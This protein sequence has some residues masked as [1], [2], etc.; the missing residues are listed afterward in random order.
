MVMPNIGAF[1]A[2][3][4]VTALFLA[5]GWIPNEYLA[6]LI[7]PTLTYLL[8]IL[9]GYTGGKIVHGVRGGVI[10]AVATVGCIIGSE[11]TMLA[12]AMVMG[13][14][15]AWVLKKFDTAV[16]PHV[17]P[18]FE[19]LVDNFSLGIIG[20]FLMVIS[21]V[22]VGP[23][24]TA[25]M[26]VLS[27][28]AQAITDAG[29]LPLLA[30]FVR[31]GQLLFLNNAINHG[32]LVPL[33]TQ[34]VADFGRSILFFVEADNSVL[35]GV[36]LAY[37]FFGTG[38]AKQSAP[39]ALIICMFGGI[40]EIQFP[41]VLMKPKLVVAP[42][43]GSMCSLAFLQLFGGGA[44]AAPSPGSIFAYLLVSPRDAIVVNMI[45]YVI[46]FGVSFLISAL[47]LKTDKSGDDDSEAVLATALDTMSGGTIGAEAAA[48]AV[49]DA[50]SGSWANVKKIVVACDAG[51]G[52]SAM[53]E[54]VL[55]N[56]LN[57]E[58]ITATV[59]HSSLNNIPDDADLVI[60]LEGLLGR[61]QASVNRRGVIFVGVPNF[62][63][64][65]DFD[66]IA[67]NLKEGRDTRLPAPTT[68]TEQENPVRIDTDI[69][70]TNNVRLNQ[71]FATKEDAIR[72]AGQ[73]L[74]DGGYVKPEYID[75]M[76]ERERDI[77]VYIGN[78]VAIPHGM[79][80]SDPLIK[81]TGLSVIT[82][83]QGV[84]FGEDKVA[85]LIVGIAALRDEQMEMLAKIALACGEVENV[86]RI[87]N[88]KTE[89]E[90]IDLL[91]TP[92]A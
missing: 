12:G 29:L 68:V 53:G 25:I 57:K 10:G 42:I 27:A 22:I 69:L 87:V 5:T 43:V 41:Y 54:G 59:T 78:G 65:N 76:L 6:E 9:I 77:S 26:S 61:A 21:Y 62:L 74:V 91:T 34:Q 64:G 30:I 7:T 90:V 33:A 71:S 80:N 83:P 73:I 40:G 8:P 49:I 75:S 66:V 45:A 3:G 19:M 58:G 84:S 15:A 28:G 44:V 46:G 48:P 86:D 32:I 70:T 1:V 89:Q 36:L 31:P 18:G 16:M 82:V 88:A 13:P 39:A 72:G 79:E 11:Y 85:Y 60:T 35:C 55:R 20:A 63:G 50:A 81:K 17:K 24:M 92:Q 52:S 37:M 51:M 56:K 47:I 38:I 14:C 4:L 2:W 23:I 67:T